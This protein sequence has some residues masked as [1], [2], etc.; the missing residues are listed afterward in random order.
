[1]CKDKPVGLDRGNYSLAVLLIL[2]SGLGFA[3]MSLFV[4]L[5]GDLPA[6]QKGFFRNF[7][8][9][10]VSL[11]IL[12]Q[13]KHGKGGVKTFW[14]A[15]LSKKNLPWLILRSAFGTA[16]IL[17][18]FYA[19]SHLPLANASVLNKLSPFFTI[20]FAALFLREKVNKAQVAGLVLAFA[21]VLLVS[22]PDAG[23]YSLAHLW[24]ILVGLAG[25]L[26]AGVAY[27]C[28]RH[29]G[30]RGADG[31]FIV[32][33]FSGFSCLALLPG[34]LLNYH[35]MTAYQWLM[36]LLI[37]CG[38]LI[39]QYGIT[40]AYRYA[41]PGQISIYD[42]SMV[43]FSVL[44]GVLVLGE[45]PDVYTLLGIAVVFLAFLVMFLYNRH[46]SEKMVSRG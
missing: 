42:Y 27:T 44:L 1:M 10:L 26:A 38:A 21:G 31:S 24:P 2:L 11:A 7:V 19:V 34:L 33:F 17:F 29:L 5:A 32:T 23:A 6:T 22:R 4:N 37:G 3:L 30:K 35:P 43:I 20:I 18:N 25:G 40:F 28:V 12:L 41:A 13:R 9:F 14:R 16:G 46:R 8:A 15:E 45:R 39:G 36:V